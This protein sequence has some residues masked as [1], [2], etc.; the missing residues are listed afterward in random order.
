MRF[1][2][3]YSFL[4]TK[5]QEIDDFSFTSNLKKAFEL[6]KINDTH[7]SIKGYFSIS[8]F[9]GSSCKRKLFYEVKNPDYKE[10]FSFDKEFIFGVGHAVHEL[11]QSKMSK[12]NLL[13]GIE[14]FF[15]DD[16]NK[17][18]GSTDGYFIDHDKKEIR[19]MDIKTSN[20]G[21][22]T[23]VLQSNKPKKDHLHQLHMYAYYLSK[24]YPDY[25]IKS[26][27]VLYVNKNQAKHI[28]DTYRIEKTINTLSNESEKE[29]LN[30]HI[31]S[32]KSA[33]DDYDCMKLKEVVFQYDPK[34][35]QEEFENLNDLKARIEANKPPN[36]ISKKIYCLNCKFVNLCRGEQW[37]KDNEQQRL[38]LKCNNGIM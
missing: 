4:E 31:E 26:M 11:I 37:V 23:Y 24:Q 19:M 35:V 12:F 5:E 21:T 25:K 18:C 7:K 32:I 13:H 6:D 30:Y 22:F 28:P 2:P 10:E 33:Y 27:H 16:E 14:Q 8:Q 20:L 34:I 15:Q 9:T 38:K 3:D 36:K 1:N 29:A 17:V